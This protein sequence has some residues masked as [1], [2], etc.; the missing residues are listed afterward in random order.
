MADVAIMQAHSADGEPSPKMKK[1][2]TRKLTDKRREQNRRAQKVYRE[3]LKKKE[4]PVGEQTGGTRNNLSGGERLF[5][6]PEVRIESTSIPPLPH[7][8]LN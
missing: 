3:K 4:E 5:S 6:L 1:P 7:Q 2:Y 8:N